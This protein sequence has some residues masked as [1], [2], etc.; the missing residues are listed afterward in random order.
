MR[1]VSTVVL[2]VPL[3][4]FAFLLQSCKKS[5][6]SPTGPSTTVSQ[7]KANG[8]MTPLSRTTVQGTVFVTDQDGAPVTGLTSSN[9]TAKLLYGP[10][11]PKLTADSIVGTILVQNTTQSGKKVAVAMTMDYS[12]TMFAGPYD[13]TAQQYNRILDMES[14]VKSF[15]NSLAVGDIAEI[16]KFGSDVDFVFPF[17][18]SKPALLLA[19]D[20][21]SFDRGSTA[22]YS[23]IY[24]GLQDAGAQS[25]STYARAVVAFTDGGENNSSVTRS[26]VFAE[27]QLVGVPV[28]TV[29]LIDSAD[30]SDPPGRNSLAELDLVEIADTTGGLYYFSP[31]AT[32]L[33]QIY[34]QISGAISNSVQVTVT[35][36]STNLPESGTTVQVVMTV[37]Y[38]G[39]STQ[40]IR[41]YTMP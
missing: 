2:L 21:S 26:D 31:N 35:W 29:G 27:A 11:V 32:E 7:L 3:L 8:T 40:F 18:S 25:A 4:T 34:Q 13:N 23:S 5:D 20:S 24:T 9:F 12:G 10:G 33:A 28:Y 38:N 17:T 16:I 36:P 15:V 37:T 22:L 30:H 39:I 19:V 1:R 41:T 14:G 6:S